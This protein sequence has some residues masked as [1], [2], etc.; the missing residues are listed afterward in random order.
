M[1]HFVYRIFK[2]FLVGCCGFFK[3]W[4]I[5][6]QNQVSSF[7]WKI[8]TSDPSDQHFY[9]ATCAKNCKGMAPLEIRPPV[10]HRP[11]HFLLLDICSSQSIYVTYLVPEFVTSEKFCGWFFKS[12]GLHCF[13]HILFRLLTY[14]PGTGTISFRKI[15]WK[16]S[17]HE[18]IPGYPFPDAP[19]EFLLSV[20][21]HLVYRV[22]YK[23]LKIIIRAFYVLIFSSGL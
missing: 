14:P 21:F 2:K 10:C 6:Y 18:S 5:S 22:L 3:H 23:H 13:V 7:S 17:L 12:V 20:T 4:K 16:C 11:H 15:A 9:M 19:F 1:I 8:I